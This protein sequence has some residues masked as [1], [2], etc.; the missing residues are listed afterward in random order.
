[1]RT[2]ATAGDCG[3]SSGPAGTGAQAF[4][5]TAVAAS[6]DF[7]I[8]LPTD[9]ADTNYFAQVTGGGLAAFLIFDVVNADNALN[10]IHVKTSAPTTIGDVMNVA[11]WRRTA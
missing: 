2:P 11:I 3:G 1:M 9:E 8:P 6:D 4:E 5:Y 10:Q 7:V